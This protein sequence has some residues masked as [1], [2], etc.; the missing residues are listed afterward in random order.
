M[1]GGDDL[2]DLWKA[3]EEFRN[4]NP[5][6]LNAL[7]KMAQAQKQ[8]R[9]TVDSLQPIVVATSN[10]TTTLPVRTEIATEG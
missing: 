4:K 8:H 7:N 6:L 10:A 9:E 2:E 3:L 5:E 1:S